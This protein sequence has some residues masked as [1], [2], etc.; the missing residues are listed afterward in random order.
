MTTV[1]QAS[2]S[3]RKETSLGET[4]VVAVLG[5]KRKGKTVL[6]SKMCYEYWMGGGRLLHMGNLSF[7]EKIEDIGILA[8]QDPLTLSNVLLYLDEAKAL[9]NSRNSNG[10]FQK[11]IGNNLMQAGHQG[12]SMIWTSQFQT[13]INSDLLDQCDYAIVVDRK[14]GQQPWRREDEYSVQKGTLKEA[15][16]CAGFDKNDPHYDE[17]AGPGRLLA[18][19]DSKEKRTV[20]YKVVTQK[21]HP[22]GPGI[23][24]YKTLHCAQRFYGLSDTTFKVD[25]LNAMLFNTDELRARKQSE[26]LGK[27]KELLVALTARGMREITPADMQGYMEGS[28]NPSIYLE[29]KDIRSF[30]KAIGVRKVV[31]REDR[32][33]LDAW[34]GSKD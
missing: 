14:S 13:G 18:C 8:D 21:S 32:W 29:L 31:Q 22:Y 11:L 4:M 20:L 7:G 27:F 33:N 30:F 34:A 28:F 26:I 12:L 3:Q 5:P 25:A 1:E 15:N 6:A 2:V 16:L 17:H 24:K 9:M 10:A 23:T 19:A